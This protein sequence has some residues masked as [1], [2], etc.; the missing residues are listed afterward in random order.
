MTKAT[1]F[2]HL[3]KRVEGF[4]GGRPKREQDWGGG[5]EEGNLRVA[6]WPE[7][8]EKKT[9]EQATAICGVGVVSSYYGLMAI[10]AGRL[11]EKGHQQGVWTAG[12]LETLN[13]DQGEKGLTQFGQKP[14]SLGAEKKPKLLKRIRKVKNKR[15][16]HTIHGLHLWG[17]PDL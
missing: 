2:F 16:Q 10:A 12:T 8:K 1:K 7:L 3:L 11:V 13:A 5:P 6:I 15:K 17:T 9:S 4:A 14:P